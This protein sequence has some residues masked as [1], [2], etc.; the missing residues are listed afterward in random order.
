M[1]LNKTFFRKYWKQKII[2]EWYCGKEGML[3]INYKIAKSED[4]N[5]E[6]NSLFEIKWFI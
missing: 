2:N 3:I 5:N 6:K 1:L 4:T